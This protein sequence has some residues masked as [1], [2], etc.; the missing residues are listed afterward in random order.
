MTKFALEKWASGAKCSFPG[1]DCSIL[2]PLCRWLLMAPSIQK[3]TSCFSCEWNTSTVDVVSLSEETWNMALW[4][5]SQLWGHNWGVRQLSPLQSC[6]VFLLV[7]FFPLCPTAWTPGQRENWI[8]QQQLM[9]L[10]AD[11]CS[12]QNPSKF[13]E[14]RY[15]LHSGW[16][17]ACFPPT[18]ACLTYEVIKNSLCSCWNN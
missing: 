4:G 9:N 7:P 10:W 14:W 1:S 11:Y 2:R 5:P 17:P 12:A 15:W 8:S 16:I 6:F 18:G 13:G 3:S